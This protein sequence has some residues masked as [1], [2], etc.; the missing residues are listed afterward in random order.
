MPFSSPHTPKLTHPS[1]VKKNQR[2][3]PQALP[4]IAAA[5]TLL[6]AP[7][8]AASVVY[9]FT[10]GSLA[11]TVSGLPAGVTASNFS[12]G[13]F[14]A[15]TL[16]SDALRLT[17][18][19]VTETTTGG[20][21]T[22]NT[23]LSFS[24]TIPSGA[25]LDLAS[26]TYDYTFSG[27]DNRSIWARTYT[28]IP[29]GNAANDTIGKFGKTSGDPVSA[30]DV[31]V[32]LDDP[33]SNPFRGSNVNNGDFTGLTDQTITFYMPMFK[34]GTVVDAE[35]IQFDNVTLN[36]IPEPSTALLGALGML[37]LLRRRR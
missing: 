31:T 3:T 27:I 7:A 35:Y 12:I 29:P 15:G 17:G 33:E 6:A 5:L 22:A 25:T 23:V 37:A 28:S 20:S 8:H 13:D 18:A 9:E 34:S 1:I 2:T 26:I 24:L 14:A 4:A 36:V 30:T 11:P 10:G 16:Q 19:D 21:I 32:S